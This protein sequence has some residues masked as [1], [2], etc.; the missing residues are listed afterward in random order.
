[1]GASSTALYNAF[2]RRTKLGKPY[3]PYFKGANKCLLRLSRKRLRFLI[4]K[5]PTFFI[6][7]EL[8]IFYFAQGH[9][10]SYEVL[11]L[12]FV[13]AASVSRTK[14]EVGGCRDYNASRQK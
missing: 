2:S 4:C 3:G 1:M 12:Q 11:L 14:D 5:L 8:G 6:V 7:V 9:N 10:L 13:A